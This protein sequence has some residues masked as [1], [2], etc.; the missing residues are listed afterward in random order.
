MNYVVIRPNGSEQKKIWWPIAVFPTLAEVIEIAQKEFP[1]TPLDKL[2]I[3]EAVT[4][5]QKSL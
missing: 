4:L 2:R 1:G 5:E 3:T